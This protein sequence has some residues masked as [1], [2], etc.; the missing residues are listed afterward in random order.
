MPSSI[1]PL[2]ASHIPGPTP[3]ADPLVS[4]LIPVYNEEVT[5]EQVVRRVAQLDVAKEILVVDDGSKD[6]S[7]EIADRLAG[8]FAAGRTIVRSLPQPQNMG[9]GAA[10]RAGIAAS[11]GD[12]VLIQD[13]DLEYD[14]ADLPA[15]LEPLITGHADVVYGSRFS[16]GQPQRAHLF[17]HYVGNKVLTLI[18]RAL[19]NTTLS[20]MEVGYKAFR[21]EIVRSLTLRSNDFRIEPELTARLLRRPEIRLYE[22]PISYF[23]RSFEEGKKITWRDGFKALRALITFRFDKG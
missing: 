19:F 15:L 10:V 8:E 18:T 3:I 11:E 17:L 23:G 1:P 6:R 2:E 5:L 14:P 16:G 20:D 21:G 22:V 7:V 13:A 12:I 9:K 4:I